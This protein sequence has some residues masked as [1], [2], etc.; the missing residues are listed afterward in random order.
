MNCELR[1]DNFTNFSNFYCKS[2]GDVLRGFLFS[3]ENWSITFLKEKEI[4]PSNFRRKSIYL[5]LYFYRT[6]FNYDQPAPGEIGFGKSEVFHVVDTL[7]NGVVGSWQVLRVGG[8]SNVEFIRWCHEF[9]VSTNLRIFRETEF[10][11]LFLC[12]VNVSIYID[13]L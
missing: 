1:H 9:S 7:H 12:T 11:Y 2:A 10:V 6:H 8:K 13:F 4:I 3:V 5:F